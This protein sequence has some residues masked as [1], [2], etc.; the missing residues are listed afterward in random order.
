METGSRAAGPLTGLLIGRNRLSTSHTS[1]DV[2]AEA[3]AVSLCPAFAIGDDA[4]DNTGQLG[5][6]AHT[7]KKRGTS[8]GPSKQN[9]TRT[10]RIQSLTL[11]VLPVVVLAVCLALE[12]C[13]C[14]T[15]L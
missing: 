15:R 13:T 12:V 10:E 2:Y 6:A 8:I 3:Q 14:F 4:L 1:A 5:F 9:L 11:T 7:K